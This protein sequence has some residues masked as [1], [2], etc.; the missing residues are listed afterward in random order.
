MAIVF[1]IIAITFV[2]LV[3]GLVGYAL[4]EL[5]PL[6]RHTDHFRDPFTGRRRWESPHLD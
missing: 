5:T 1:S 3:L 4:F 6:A 2:V